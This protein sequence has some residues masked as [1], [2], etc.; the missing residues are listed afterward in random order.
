MNQRYCLDTNVLIVAWQTYYSPAICPS[1]WDLMS[2]LGEQGIIFMPKEV[3]EELEKTEDD[4]LAWVK[5]SKIP[6]AKTDTAVINCV[7]R[8]YEY[9]PI[10]ERL[11]DSTKNRSLADPWVIAHAMKFNACVITKEK[12]EEVSHTKIRIPNVCDNMGVKWIDD[13]TFCKDMGIKFSC[14]MSL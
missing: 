9:N 1:Y 11:I 7:R 8:I 5:T 10:H 12:R 2:K 14:S 13:F 4:L 6:V 3:F